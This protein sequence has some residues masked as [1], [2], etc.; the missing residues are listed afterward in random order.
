MIFNKSISLKKCISKIICDPLFENP[1]SKL[2]L[3]RLYRSVPLQI[4]QKEKTTNLH[5][6]IGYAISAQV[7]NTFQF[8]YKFIKTDTLKHVL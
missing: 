1:W 7:F 2:L 8:Y 3:S 6:W 4:T 5:I